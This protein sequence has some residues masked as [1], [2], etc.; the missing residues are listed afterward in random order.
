M[1][2]PAP[3][4]ALALASLLASAAAAAGCR[5][6]PPPTP[7]PGAVQHVVVI[8]LNELGSADALR[9][10]VEVSKSFEQIPGVLSVSAGPPLPSDRAV[11]DDSFD[12][13]LVV[14]LRDRAALAAYLKHP[15]HLQAARHATTAAESPA[16]LSVQR[17]PRAGLPAPV[18]GGSGD[19]L[20]TP[21]AGVG[22]EAPS[23]APRA[24]ARLKRVRVVDEAHLPENLEATARP[25]RGPIIRSS[26]AAVVVLALPRVAGQIVCTAVA[27][28]PAG[29]ARPLRPPDLTHTPR[30]TPGG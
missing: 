26:T 1:T 16:R 13:A 21:G 4:R 25:P 28:A 12:V 8:W 20:C 22:V 3:I 30:G 6:A 10:L 14:T 19:L 11:V 17:D 27:R 29:H 23:L 24:A 2:V 9:Q 7:A 18:E 15:I 5:T